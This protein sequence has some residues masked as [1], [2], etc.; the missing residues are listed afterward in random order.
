M[1]HAYQGGG[2]QQGWHA[3]GTFEADRVFL[4]RMHARRHVVTDPETA[5][6]FFVPVMLSAM[7]GNLWEPQD[8]LAALVRRI[9][10][11]YPFWNRS[12]GADHVFMTTQDL[13]GCWVSP[14]LR[15]SIIVSHFG[16][17]E[18]L[19]VWMS[20]RRWRL[21]VGGKT[22]RNGRAPMCDRWTGEPC[23]GPLHAQLA[24]GC[25]DPM[26]DSLSESWKGPGR[27]GMGRA[28]T[29]QKT[30]SCRLTSRY[31]MPSE[32]EQELPRRQPWRSVVRHQ[33][34]IVPVKIEPPLATY[35]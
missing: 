19:Q 11:E 29:E 8:Y 6:L 15:R 26:R 7:R 20:S 10:R 30:L 17:T 14:E 22:E 3:R 32:N 18:S 34:A 23:F 1:H 13:G 9:R 24:R 28:S 21:A 31:R 33:T 27:C 12:L 5:V 25:V 2:A 35:C 16:F 4:K